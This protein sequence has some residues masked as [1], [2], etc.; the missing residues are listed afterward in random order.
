MALEFRQE[1]A[2]LHL[3]TRQIPPGRPPFL[4]EGSC[5]SVVPFELFEPRS[6]LV[7][8]GAGSHHRAGSL[9][10][11]R[12]VATRSC[13]APATSGRFT[14]QGAHFL[15][16]FEDIPFFLFKKLGLQVPTGG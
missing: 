10:P 8:T 12:R 13:P 5:W 1:P 9:E 4:L 11:N 16:G 3:Q 15:A 14:L 7:R 6:P 2:K